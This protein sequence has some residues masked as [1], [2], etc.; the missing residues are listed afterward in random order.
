M[1]KTTNAGHADAM[2]AC[3]DIQQ[4][5]ST[6]DVP[7][8]D[9]IRRWAMLALADPSTADQATLLQ[10]ANEQSPVELTIRV[11]D[12]DEITELNAT[13]RDKHKPTNVLSFP[14]D[15]P[16]D[17][18]IPL[19]GDIII[20]ADVVNQEASEQKKT[21]D[22]HWA[23]MVVHGVLHLL[24]YDHIEDEEAQVMEGLETRLLTGAGF[25]PPYSYDQPYDQ[26]YDRVDDHTDS[27][28][29]T[30]AATGL[31]QIRQ[32]TQQQ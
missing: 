4:A 15:L 17:I 19:L 20:C 16:P 22:A 28:L 3:I 5:S 1:N 8:A 10:T 30:D 27:G 7:D 24:G 23:H 32:Q 29:D 18:D 9:R 11:C 2:E 13:Y 26:P 25:A 12:I 14:A 6:D 31:Q 21:G